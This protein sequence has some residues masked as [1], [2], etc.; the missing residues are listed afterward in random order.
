MNA[1]KRGSGTLPEMPKLPNIAE[2]ENNFYHG[3]RRGRSGEKGL[4]R[5]YADE[6]GSGTLP[7]MPRLPK[8]AESGT[9]LLPQRSQRNAEG[10]LGD[11]ICEIC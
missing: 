5:I 6:R 2:I 4:P 11:R 10:R 7:E 9:P 1:D 3:G 8:I